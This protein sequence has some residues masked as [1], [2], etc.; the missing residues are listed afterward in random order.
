[1]EKRESLQEELFTD[2]ER[3]I[4]S[5]LSS[6]SCLPLF[7]LEGQPSDH[8]VLWNLDLMWLTLS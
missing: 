8:N 2:Q 5:L 6:R 4:L 1:M 3:A 7:K